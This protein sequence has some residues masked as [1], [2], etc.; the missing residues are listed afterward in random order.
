MKKVKFRFSTIKHGEFRFFGLS[1]DFYHLS[2]LE[3]KLESLGFKF[4]SFI[5]GEGVCQYMEIKD[6]FRVVVVLGNIE[7]P[8]KKY[9]RTIDPETP[10]KV[11]F[12]NNQSMEMWYNSQYQVYI[13][14]T[15]YTTKEGTFICSKTPTHLIKYHG[16]MRP[17]CMQSENKVELHTGS[18]VNCNKSIIVL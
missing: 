12:K 18:V 6:R 11:V 3:E 16:K 13:N 9:L 2:Q 4:T 1:K 10:P 14:E 17:C 7:M 5:K 8:L 15:M